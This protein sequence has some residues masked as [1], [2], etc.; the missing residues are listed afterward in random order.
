LL[1]DDRL[2]LNGTTLVNAGSIAAGDLRITADSL[3]NQGTVEGDAALTLGVADLTN[4]GALRSGGT[5]TLN[6]DTLT[7]SG[8]LSATALLLNLTRQVSN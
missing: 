4:R 6:G 3:E 8:E 1:A 2:T 5:L 7:S